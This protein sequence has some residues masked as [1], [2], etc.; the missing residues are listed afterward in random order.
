MKVRYIFFGLSLCLFFS[1]PITACSSEEKVPELIETDEQ[2]LIASS[3]FHPSQRIRYQ[4]GEKYGWEIVLKKEVKAVTVTEALTLPSAPKTWGPELVGIKKREISAD[5]KTCTTT[6]VIN[7]AKGKTISKYWSIAKGDPLGDYKVDVS[8]NGEHA[9]TF[10]FNIYDS[11]AVNTSMA[12][13]APGN[14]E[15][16]FSEDILKKA[17]NNDA[18][19]QVYIGWCYLL[20][21]G[22]PMDGEEAAKWMKK[23]ADQ[24]EPYGQLVYGDML[25]RGNVIPKNINEAIK[26]LEKAQNNGVMQAAETLSALNLKA[27]AITDLSDELVQKASKGDAQSQCELGLCYGLGKGVTMDKAESFKWIEKAAKQDHPYALAFLG[28]MYFM[29]DGVDI[30]YQKAKACFE[31][32]KLQGLELVDE[33]LE[34]VNRLID[35]TE[36]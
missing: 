7:P 10:Y 1:F 20:G 31:K 12:V 33:K 6:E 36:K 24:N 11:T 5:L 9:K 32:A 16:K 22:V 34:Q 15:I 35:K 3:V 30:D 23:A 13:P 21:K 19:A 27:P 28:D 2:N 14:E 4:V 29:G 8:I 26:Y 17:Q 18:S 25:Y